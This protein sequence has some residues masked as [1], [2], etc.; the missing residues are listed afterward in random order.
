MYTSTIGTFISYFCNAYNC[1]LLTA[2][3]TCTVCT[4]VTEKYIHVPHVHIYMKLHI[5]MYTCSSD[6]HVCTYMWVPMYMCMHTCTTCMYIYLY[7]YVRISVTVA[8]YLISHL[9]TSIVSC[10]GHCMSLIWLHYLWHIYQSIQSHM[11]SMTFCFL[12]PF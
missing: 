6:I 12:L 9:L 1:T 4:H 7:I 5:Y 11:Q 3:S 2:D 10:T 8:L